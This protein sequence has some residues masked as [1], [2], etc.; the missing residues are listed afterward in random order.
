MRF[1][2]KRK[3]KLKVKALLL[4]AVITGLLYLFFYSAIFTIKSVEVSLGQIDCADEEQIKKSSNIPGQN[5]F[6]LNRDVIEKTLK[7]KFICIQN[8]NLSKLFPNKVKLEV[9]PRVPVVILTN[10]NEP[11]A[12]ESAILENMATPSAQFSQNSFLVDNMGVIFGKD[13]GQIMAP[14]IFV[15]NRTIS[16]GGQINNLPASLLILEKLK[17]FGLN[18]KSAG[19]VDENLIIFENNISKIIFRLDFGVDIQVASLQLILEKAKID[20]KE[21]EFID[22]RFDK[23][24]VRFATKGKI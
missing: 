23:P 13:T 19:I 6:L 7:N 11:Q 14:K 10:L 9:L 24:I 16:I 2:K 18:V 20:S 1:K 5:F 8:I 15:N 17:T 4:A 12:T 21:L 22:L 3:A